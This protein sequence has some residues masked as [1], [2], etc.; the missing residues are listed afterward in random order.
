MLCNVSRNTFSRVV[1]E[2]SRRRL[3]VLNYRS[4]TVT[5]PARLRDG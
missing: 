1:G 2:L 5:E 3:V 4:L